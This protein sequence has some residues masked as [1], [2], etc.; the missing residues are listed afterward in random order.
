MRRD[1]MKDDTVSRRQM[2][3]GMAASALAGGA[4][5]APAPERYKL[6]VMASMYSAVPLD[7]AMARIKKAGYHYICAGNSHGGEVVFAPTLPN[8]SAPACCAA[9]KTWECS[10]RARSG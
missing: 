4:H 5:A 7:D 8:P 2:L 9:S 3:A 1:R 10:M 6:G